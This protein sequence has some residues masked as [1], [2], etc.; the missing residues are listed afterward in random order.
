[1]NEKKKMNEANLSRRQ[2][3]DCPAS[4]MLHAYLQGGI[5]PPESDRISSHLE[6]CP[7]CEETASAFE[8]TTDSLL[9]LLRQGPKPG[10]FAGKFAGEA[11][12]S[13]ALQLGKALPAALPTPPVEFDHPQQLREYRLLAKLGQGGM[14]TVYR[15]VHTKLDKT[16]ALKVLPTDRKL[17]EAAVARFEREMKAVARLEHPNI[18]RATDAGQCGETHFLV[19]E[20]V[21]GVDLSELVRRHGPLTVGAACEIIRQAAIGLQHA[22]ENGMVHRDIKPQNLMVTSDGTAKILDL[23]LALINE[24]ITQQHQEITSTGQIMGTLDYMAPEQI[25]DSH[26]VDQRADIYSLGATLYKLLAGDAPFADRR[27]SSPF[28]LM[29]ALVNDPPT[30]IRARRHG[31]PEE[32]V[33]ILERML[34]KKPEERFASARQVAAALAPFRSLNDLLAL[35]GGA[36]VLAIPIEQPPVAPPPVEPAKLEIKIA[37]APRRLPQA[38]SVRTV[39]IAV[40]IGLVA[41]FVLGLAIILRMKTPNGEVIVS[42]DEG[43]DREAVRIGVTGDGAMKIAEA[44][45][46]W[47]LEIHEGK[48]R[49][50]LL[51][52]K[53]EFKL[54]DDTI[55]VTRA[56][57]T[58]LKVELQEPL[59]DAPRIQSRPFKG[60]PVNPPSD[61]STP[62]A[63]KSDTTTASSS[64]PEDS[65]PETSSPLK[66]KPETSTVD[67]PKQQPRPAPAVADAAAMTDREA[68]QWV[69]D[70][71]GSV[72]VYEGNEPKGL[73]ALFQS[74]TI[75]KP[76]QALPDVFILNSIDLSGA[77]DLNPADLAKLNGLSNLRA[78]DFSAADFSDE[79]LM[80][81]NVPPTLT[82]LRLNETKITDACAEQLASFVGLQALDL[83]GTN[84]G[85][86][87]LLFIGKLRNLRNLQLAE[88]RLTNDGLVHLAGN[89]RKLSMLDASRTKLSDEGLLLITPENFPSLMGLS[90][91]QTDV[92]REGVSKTKQQHPRCLVLGGIGIK[93]DR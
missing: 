46:E 26:Q 55:E 41:A 75:I 25:A 88:T 71:G 76:G 4:E 8:E 47:I 48:Y 57:K 66:S 23:G 38:P 91:M 63:S 22:H 70:L 1:M 18:V 80:S 36:P 68:A 86:D 60:T 10:K 45:N 42:F 74:A 58:F 34:A 69:L 64:N 44:N 93:F 62:N 51:G 50:E 14:G 9:R 73:F 17:N 49:A 20:F 65:Q 54:S 83:S 15:A 52:G 77:T 72:G 85:D 12:L 6:A 37:A 11:G 5:E 67:V 79:H 19:M 29:T 7:I 82:S 27:L 61:D 87:A 39:G 92:T 56:K 21:D 40:L 84:I 32:L 81:L 24:P 2:L 3:D 16:V 30:S 43:V 33:A 13:Q 90:A 53:D 89:L 59:K 28:K 31:L 78:I 35:V